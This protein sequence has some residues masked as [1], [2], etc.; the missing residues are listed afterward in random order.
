MNDRIDNPATLA[1]AF[2]DASPAD[3]FGLSAQSSK[4]I[5]YRF[6]GKHRSR[7]WQDVDEEESR[8]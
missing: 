1:S 4:R 5:C 6:K 8:R 3:G 2:I 7:T